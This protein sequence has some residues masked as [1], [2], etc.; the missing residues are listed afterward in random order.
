MILSSLSSCTHSK[1][2]AAID[3]LRRRTDHAKL[4]HLQRSS[5][6]QLFSKNIDRSQHCIEAFLLVEIL[7][8]TIITTLAEMSPT[9]TMD[10][11]NVALQLIAAVKNATEE[12]TKQI[13]SAIKQNGEKKPQID[14]DVNSMRELIISKLQRPFRC[15]SCHADHK[16]ATSSWC[17]RTLGQTSSLPTQPLCQESSSWF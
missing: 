12:A 2:P 11:A 7:T 10:L 13:V 9:V 16:Q 3:A 6:L 8:D 4:S 15:S 1:V 5:S 14:M 17:F